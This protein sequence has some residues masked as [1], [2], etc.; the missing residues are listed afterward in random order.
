LVTWYLSIFYSNIELRNVLRQ[1]A[2]LSADHGISQPKSVANLEGEKMASTAN[3][4]W[5][6]Q[7]IEI[8]IK[9]LICYCLTKRG[10]PTTIHMDIIKLSTDWA[11]SEVFSAKVVWLFSAVEVLTAIGFW[12][13]GRTAMARIFP[14]PLLIMGLFL[15]AV[16]TGLYG[17]NN[18]R[19]ARFESEAQLNP[20]AFLDAEILRTAKS[21]QDLAM[22]FKIL[23][24]IIIVAAVV[25]IL[26]PGT[27]WRAISV[28]IVLTAAFL[29]VV[30]SN[31]AAR[32][33]DYHTELIRLSR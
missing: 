12:Y 28:T 3:K 26:V 11:R 31:T 17:A 33:D 10:Q 24:A 8:M 32:N 6:V 29:M 13:W 16:G 18:P 20:K 4:N 27:A 5:T 9:G 7:Q 30:D 14:W 2:N 25:I 23:P 1:I 21:Q 15:V 22:V 19:I